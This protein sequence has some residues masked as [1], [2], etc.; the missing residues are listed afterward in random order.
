[1]PKGK[2]DKNGY[3]LDPQNVSGS[4][5]YYE[6]PRGLCCIFQPRDRKGNLLFATPAWHIPWKFLDRTMKRRAV[7]LKRR[8][9]TRAPT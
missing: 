4:F 5:W 8:K 7:A 3:S 1:M 2:F 6:E 9:R